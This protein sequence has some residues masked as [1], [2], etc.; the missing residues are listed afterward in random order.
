MPAAVPEVRITAQNAQPIS[1]DGDYVLYW[2]VA[3]RRTRHSFALDRAV[4]HCEALGKPLLVLE[5]L[6]AEYP[7][8]NDRHHAFVLRGMADNRAACAERGITC[9]SYVELEAGAGSGLLEA[10]AARAC[11]V[12]TDDW[13]C[14]FIPRMV[15]AAAGG[16]PVRVEAVDGNGLYP[17]HATDRVFGRAVDFRRHLQKT[18]A[19]HL[20]DLPSADPL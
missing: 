7:W 10:L 1:P 20:G 2:M 11:A 12:V 18:L 15:A 5:A 4:E 3:S 14:L 6:R 9:H 13:P 16:V 8:A 19:D 17:M